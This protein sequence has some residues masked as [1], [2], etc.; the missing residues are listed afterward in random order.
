MQTSV[1]PKTLK[2]LYLF[3]GERK[4]MEKDW[5]EGIMPDSHLIGFNHLKQF[6]IEASY[7]E[8]KFLNYIR[9]KNFNLT[10]LILIPFLGR[11]DIVFSG[12]SLFLPFA[13]KVI[14]RMKRPKFVWYN[15][16]F[17]NA[18]K[19]NSGR[20][21]KLWI[22]RKTIASLDA[23][24]CPSTAQKQFL[25]DQGF[26]QAKIFFV[27]NGI[28]IDFMN[29]KLAEN[30]NIASSDKPFILSVGKDMGR[31]YETLV[32]AVKGLP[33]EVRIVALPRNVGAVKDIPPNVKVLGF[34]PFPKLLGLYNEALFVVI[35]TKSER[36]LDASDCSGQ[37]VLLDAMA[38]GKAIIAS[39]RA[40]LADYFN[41]GKE[42]A[43]VPSEDSKAL[44]QAI[45]NFLENRALMEKF[46]EAAKERSV[47]FTTRNMAE[48]L[49]YIFEKI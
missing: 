43:V 18:L 10:N 41:D 33:V 6:G 8:N 26:D 5:Q 44:R 14:F 36:H 42:G 24:I 4:K 27:P 39:E 9:K 12:A 21:L 34:V 48:T 15:T 20:R 7:I 30:G 2:V 11:Y 38:S 22:L 25:V 1:T 3:A 17:T 32:Q 13:V 35:P 29:R 19:R 47:A 28:D 16:F 46:G 49:S 37:Y 45:V 31:D 40:T 23:I